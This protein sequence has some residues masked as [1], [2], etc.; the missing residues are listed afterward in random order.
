VHTAQ[1]DTDAHRQQ[2]FPRGADQLPGR[3]QPERTRQEGPPFKVL[4]AS[5]Q[6]P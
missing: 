3:S 4:R 2:T 5:G 1:P 6:P